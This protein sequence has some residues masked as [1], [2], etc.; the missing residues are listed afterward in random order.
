MLLL[1]WQVASGSTSTCGCGSASG[2]TSVSG[3]TTG[4]ASDM[5]VVVRVALQTIRSLKQCP[6]PPSSLSSDDFINHS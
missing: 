1:S 2:T 4:R 3:G 6:D 5:R